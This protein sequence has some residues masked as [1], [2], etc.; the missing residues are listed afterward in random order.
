MA[1]GQYEQSRAA[2]IALA[3]TQGWLVFKTVPAGQEALIGERLY[4]QSLSAAGAYTF[5]IHTNNWDAIEVALKPSAV[6][7][8]FAPTLV[9]LGMTRQA[10]RQTAA[11]ANFA[12]GT[13]QTLAITGLRGT[14]EA[15]LSFTIPGGGS[16]A[17][18]DA[19]PS[20]PTAQAEYNGQ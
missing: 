12:A 4:G 19:S 7:G 2:D 18:I 17:F 9:S 11:G 20:T 3:D 1:T 8:T 16:I 6:S 13:A 14:K 15:R 10:A 5:E